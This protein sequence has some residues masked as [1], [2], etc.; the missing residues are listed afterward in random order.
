MIPASDLSRFLHTLV[1]GDIAKA[2]DHAATF[3]E[4]EDRFEEGYTN[5]LTGMLSSMENNEKD[6]LLYKILHK[7]LPEDSL[8]A[9]YERCTIRAAESFRGQD[10]RGYEQ[11]WGH[12]CAYFLDDLKAGLDAYR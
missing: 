5:A 12:V 2:R 3:P 7:E 6:S 8:R 10:E 4:P 1:S 9:Q 11:A